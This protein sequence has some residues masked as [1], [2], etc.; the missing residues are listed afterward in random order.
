MHSPIIASKTAKHANIYY[1]DGNDDTKSTGSIDKDTFDYMEY[2]KK[3]TKDVVVLG[4][5]TSYNVHAF[6]GRI[7]LPTEG[8]PIPFILDQHARMQDNI[9]LIV[10]SLAAS[11]RDVLNNTSNLRCFV[12]RI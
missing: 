6:K 7:Y 9:N 11:A 8:R 5:V 4:R 3:D 1:N 10:T 2:S 12:L